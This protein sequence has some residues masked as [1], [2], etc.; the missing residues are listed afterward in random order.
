MAVDYRAI[1]RRAGGS[2]V[3]PYPDPA[4]PPPDGSIIRGI[5]HDTV[6]PPPKPRT[7]TLD[8]SGQAADLGRGLQS[9]GVDTTPPEDPAWLRFLGL[10]DK[11]RQ[12]TSGTVAGLQSGQ[13]FKTALGS[14]AAAFQ[15]TAAKAPPTGADYLN[16]LA[17]G[18]VPVASGVAGILNKSQVGRFVG[19][20]AIDIGMDPTS[21]I[22]L[23]PGRF[24]AKEASTF[25]GPIARR[26]TV[27]GIPF[28]PDLAPAFK[29]ATGAVAS[30]PGIRQVGDALGSVFNPRHIPT[31]I[32]GPVRAAITDANTAI[33]A[34]DTLLPSAES[35][36]I[37]DSLT[38]FRG[39]GSPD[40]AKAASGLIENLPPM[41]AA[42]KGQETMRR[43]TEARARVGTA[44]A[45]AM[46]SAGDFGKNMARNDW[47]YA[48]VINATNAPPEVKAMA[49]KA[50]ASF[51]N[52]VQ[53]LLGIGMDVPTLDN[54]VM[55]LYDDPFDLVREKLDMWHRGGSVTA[56]GS[57]P[58][59]IKDRT[60]PDMATA[61]S[62][63]LHP[64][65]DIRVL[66]AVHAAATEGAI[67]RHKLGEELKALGP[68][69]IQEK[70]KVSM[71]PPTGWMQVA[72]VP[73]LAG[74]YV[75]PQVGKMMT[76]LAPFISAAPEGENLL[77][78][79]NATI[80]H[81]FKGFSLMTG[82]FHARNLSGNIWLNLADGV[83]NPG[84]YAQAAAV[85]SGKVKE[86]ELNGVKWTS[87]QLM[88]AFNDAGLAGQGIFHE[89]QGSGRLASQAE[90]TV[91]RMDHPI[92]SLAQQLI[93][94]QAGH[95]L[96]PIDAAMNLSRAFGE[97]TDS[98]GRMTNFLHK[99][100][101]GATKE[102]AAETVKNALFD[103]GELTVMER[104]AR[105][106]L[107]P[108]YPW[109]RKNLP[110]E[111]EILA[112]KP[113][114]FT[115]T[116]HVRANAVQQTGVDESHLP[117][118]SRGAGAMP[119]GDMGG[120]NALYA[121]LNL[122]MYDLAAVH[123][124]KDLQAYLRQL[125][126]IATPL[127][128]VAGS[129]VMN[130]QGLTGLPITKYPDVPDQAFQD[131]VKYILASFGGA[132]GRA[133][134]SGQYLQDAAN[135]QAV[136]ES[137][138]SLTEVAPKPPTPGFGL[139]PLN[140]QSAPANARGDQLTELKRLQE[141]QKLYQD[142]MGK[143]VPTVAELQA[144]KPDPNNPGALISGLIGANAG[145]IP[146][147]GINT[148][149]PI[150]QSAGSV[151]KNIISPATTREQVGNAP[152][153]LKRAL[154]DSVSL[155]DSGWYAAMTKLMQLESGG[156]AVAYNKT[157]VLNTWTRPGQPF[158][159]NAT[160]LFQM[161]PSTFAKNAAPG[162]TD[163]WNAYDNTL[164]AIRYIKATY[165][166]PDVILDP[167]N[168]KTHN[169]NGSYKGY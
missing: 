98:W 156:N 83:S 47:Q 161:L 10:L 61:I 84:R 130:Q 148:T 87:E 7:P 44:K 102:Q 79:V 115:E 160:G 119:V 126:N 28:S 86:V 97:K 63:G 26:L 146:G 66:A 9:V 110:K 80:M 99:L 55:H 72:A 32:K 33:R 113:G 29:A 53:R 78:A 164:A 159:E 25:A 127:A 165:K 77:K 50:S 62:L 145:R 39:L 166:H 107:I 168:M 76:N 94:G 2:Q 90:Q 31:A 116:E 123:D 142:K 64:K 45:N 75:H 93:P 169:P 4:I 51:H 131:Y 150:S 27:A 34:N 70:T 120:G 155:I 122:P 133:V 30:T 140:V 12:F 91:A 109:L 128:S 59:F 134:Q 125:Y 92:G 136:K 81:Y 121:T 144:P 73:N 11:P 157:P 88:K 41:T 3:A 104:R 96:G 65:T 143:P 95:R 17:A 24:L 14:G 85:L 21:Y 132:A 19:G 138:G 106:Y 89:A 135:A 8:A 82:G 22:G 56:P 60:I 54:Y 141:L 6:N 68:L 69:V 48:T 67:V 112:T 36:A 153:A 58:S 100:D 42:E 118:W 23:G 40:A 139:L 52:D 46:F 137:K 163:I 103:Y 158:N 13:D 74:F 151:I 105:A 1:L 15:G 129:I 167:K 147:S 124:P 57:S 5:L 43:L 18:N 114:M 162:H 35:R 38:G 111:L 152:A 16:Q 49:V 154:E 149:I 71:Y 108:F 20:S 101:L 37:R 117:S